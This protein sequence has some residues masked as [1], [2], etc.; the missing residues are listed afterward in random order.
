[1]AQSRL[2]NNRRLEEEEKQSVA[3]LGDAPMAPTGPTGRGGDTVLA[4]DALLA[5]E[6]VQ[7]TARLAGREG[8]ILGSK[9][10]QKVAN[11]AQKANQIN[12]PQ[13]VANI[14][15]GSQLARLGSMLTPAG[16]YTA[17]DLITGAVREDGRGL[18]EMVADALGG[19]IGRQ[20]YGG[21]DGFGDNEGMR[22]LAMENQ[23]REAAGEAALSASESVAFLRGMDSNQA[24]QSLQPPPEDVPVGSFVSPEGENIGM[25][26]GQPNAPITQQQLDA[27][28]GQMVDTGA[29]FISGGLTDASGQTIPGPAGRP[30]GMKP[31]IDQSGQVAFADPETANM[32]NTLAGKEAQE[33]RSAQQ[34]FLA[35]EAAKQM[36]N[37]QLQAIQNSAYSQ[38]SKDLQDRLAKSS[39]DRRSSKSDF[40]TAVSDR[41]RRAAR[42]EGMS[43]ADLVDIA[44]GNAPGAS[45][46]QVA[47]GM[48][49]Q[50]LNGI[51]PFT[52]NKIADEEEDRRRQADFDDARIASLL[53]EDPTRL[54]EVQA[55]AD[56]LLDNYMG[57]DGEGM[58]DQEREDL[59]RNL[60]IRLLL[61]NLDYFDNPFAPTE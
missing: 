56:A 9:P 46:R 11:L 39:E 36:S 15:K 29:S 48:K 17:A 2:K 47:R 32:M 59:R 35:S 43:M 14:A 23:R 45:P 18:T 12:A 19:L 24:P 57:Q 53:K 22:A 55:Q 38:A 25:F 33:N 30:E 10:V 4:Q 28:A 50:Q 6:G 21:G 51:N 58:T 34:K 26:E 61:P 16:L 5:A 31:F 49:V 42:G 37:R 1:M 8:R 52:G 20:M 40:N 54:E 3:M 60:I 44:E 13:A 7:D 41:D 27:M